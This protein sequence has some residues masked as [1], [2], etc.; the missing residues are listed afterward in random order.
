LNK[1]TGFIEQKRSFIHGFPYGHLAIFA[2]NGLLL[3]DEKK[4]EKRLSGGKFLIP[5]QHTFRL[6]EVKH[7]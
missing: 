2:I 5:L 3:F 4:A 6:N 1:R 7:E